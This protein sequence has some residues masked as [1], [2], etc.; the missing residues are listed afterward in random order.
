MSMPSPLAEPL[1]FDAFLL[2]I[3]GRAGRF[4][5]HDG[6]VFAMAGG[7]RNHS[8][9]T[10]AALTALRSR[11]RARGCE[12]HGPDLFVRRDDS[13]STA[14][15][16]DVFVRCGPPPPGDQRW[17]GDPVIVVEVLSPSTMSFDRGD[18]LR[19]YFGFATLQHL[20]ILYQDEHRA[21]MWTRPAAGS[22]AT[23]IEGTPL[24]TRVVA[25]GLTSSLSIAALDATIALSEFY[26]GVD[27]AVST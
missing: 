25:N 4:E 16:P 20:I 18:K 3:E 5:L 24:W 23:D 8:L 10:V 6:E 27:I 22:T 11:A 7:S 15:S 19:R 26:D 9:V 1:D 13:E 12:T 17:A 14:L 21:E 2:A